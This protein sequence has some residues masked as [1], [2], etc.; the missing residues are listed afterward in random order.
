MHR[1]LAPILGALAFCFCLPA[2]AETVAFTGARLIPIAGPE[3]DSGT[4]VIRDGRIAAV[5]ATGA[6]RIP[7][8]ARRIEMRGR[9]IMPGLVDSH[10]HI[11]GAAGGDRSAPIQPEVRVMDAINVRDSGIQKAQAGGITTVNIMPGSG[12]LLS[13]QT[14]YLKLRDGNTIDD[15]IIP[16]AD[17]S[18]AGGIKMANGTN[19]RRDP[20]FPGTRAKAAALVREQFVKAQ[21]Y[22]EKMRIDDPAK[23]P[24][25]NLGL[26]A[27]VDVLERKRVVH[28]HTHRHDDILTVLRLAEEFGFRVVLQHVSEG[29]RVADAIAAA[30]VPASIIVID[31]PGGKLEARELSYATGKILHEAGALVGFHTDDGIT[32]SRLFLRSAGI[33]VRAGMP[34]AA[35]LEAMTINNARM[36]DL[37]ERMGTLEPGKDADFIV[38][39]GDPLSVYT[40]VLE[41]WVDG[42]KVFDRADPKDRLYAV[43]GYGASRDQSL[44]LDCM[45]EG[46]AR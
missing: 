35:A 3:I 5:G 12:H 19:P 11:G 36:L 6:V 45:G 46:D 14:I 21:E 7:A 30:G 34:R 38:L 41:T 13:G 23:R 40:H 17:G 2:A 16:L 27:L 32:D 29:W 33:A 4:L 15:L 28:H 1:L 43:G 10:S 20:P 9:T 8:G 24:E 44:H 39:S 18:P 25:R 42:V 37:H 26:E 31:S 22:R